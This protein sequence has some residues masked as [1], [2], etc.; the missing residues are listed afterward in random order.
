MQKRGKTAAGTQRW[1]CVSCSQSHSLGHD[2]QKLGQLLDR[3][4]RWLL[5]KN[6][7]VEFDTT[8]TDRTWRN[9]ISWC[10][11][12][13]PRLEPNIKAHEI[14]LLDGIRIGVYVCLIAKTTK[15][16]I[17][18]QWVGWESSLSWS[19]LLNK[20][21][22]PIVVACDGQKGILLAIARSWPKTRVQR[23]LVHVERN[24][25]T[26]LTLHPQSEA[27]RK[28]FQLTR[29]LWQV[30]TLEQAGIWQRSLENWGQHYSDLIR[31]RSFYESSRRWWYTHKRLRSAYR[32]LEKLL[33]DKQLFT[34]LD[35][36]T[37][38]IP[39][40]TNHVEGGINSQL[41]TLLKL[42]RGL[43]QTHQMRLVDW[44][45]YS[46]SEGQKPPRNFL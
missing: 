19:I 36:T 33:K 37:E 7:Q 43:S 32:Q 34:Y 8:I 3:F 27:G 46:R 26:K 29:D 10:W 41:R 17:G 4:V 31:E 45:L 13:T 39:R 1:F 28:L 24:I 6:S 15:G 2:T 35:L 16:V 44:Y 38:P 42:H 12:I 25:R 21:P 30:Q 5:G 22:S 14:I 20:I 40:T 23:C 18:W 9:Q 11:E